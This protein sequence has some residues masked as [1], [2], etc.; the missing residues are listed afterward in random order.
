M[1][2]RKIILAVIVT[3][4][5]PLAACGDGRGGIVTGTY[6]QSMQKGQKEQEE[7]AAGSEDGGTG[8]SEAAPAPADD[9]VTSD[10]FLITGHDMQ[11][12]CLVLEQLASGKQY[13]YSYSVATRFLDKYGNRA[14]AAE[15]EPGR[16]ICLGEKDE[17]GRLLEAGL[18]DKV[19]EYPGVTRFSADEGS[20]VFRIADTNY[21]CDEDVFVHEDGVQKSL[22]DLTDMDTLRVVGL[23]KK[24]LSVSVTT[25][26]GELTLVNTSVFDGSFIQVGR[27]IFSEINGETT[28]EVPEGTYTVAVAN[29]GYGGS[30]EVAIEGGKETV[31]DLD[32]LKGDGPK[33]GKILFAVDVYGALVQVD[34]RVVDYTGPVEIT[35]G[36]HALTVSAEGYETMEKR[37]FVNSEEATII[38]GLTGDNL[39]SAYGSDEAPASSEAASSEAASSEAASSE[40]AEGD[41]SAAGSL[42]GSKAG[43]LAG[44]KGG[45]SGGTEG[46]EAASGAELDAIVDGLLDRDGDGEPDATTDYL[47]TIIDALTSMVGDEG[48]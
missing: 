45:A 28:I 24:V 6:Y 48:E 13:M 34:G 36:E 37:L 20:G 4:L 12:E 35:Y 18:S 41:G 39:F 31:L 15:F 29:D 33:V 47:S 21:A 26:H 11:S 2:L 40:A 8:S 16:V 30:T 46:T 32:S 19:W 44:S 42:A 7:R 43:S 23:G 22:S 17:A 38:I 3:L 10:L 5:L 9:E 25:G 27:D 14:T 1:T